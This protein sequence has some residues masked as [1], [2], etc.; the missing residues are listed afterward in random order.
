M[1]HLQLLI[2]KN[3]I[4]GVP[5]KKSRFTHPQWKRVGNKPQ[6]KTRSMYFFTT[7]HGSYALDQGSRNGSFSGWINIFVINTSISMPNFEVLDARIASALNKIINNYQF[8]RRISLEE[9][10]A[11]KEDLFLRGFPTFLTSTTM[12]FRNSLQLWS[13]E[14]GNLLRWEAIM[15]NFPVTSETSKVLRVSFL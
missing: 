8:K 6:F 5:E 10:K 2:R 7:H 15:I 4:H 11:Q 12:S 3:W 1:R 13:I 9:Q 14:Q